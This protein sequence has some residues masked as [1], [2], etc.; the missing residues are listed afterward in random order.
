M[1]V[2]VCP[3]P[4]ATLFIYPRVCRSR[5]CKHLHMC[6]FIDEWVGRLSSFNC[7]RNPAEQ[8]LFF[9]HRR[10]GGPTPL[11]KRRHGHPPPPHRPFHHHHHDHHNQNTHRHNHHTHNRHHPQDHYHSHRHHQ[12][13]RRRQGHGCQ[14]HYHHRPIIIILV[15]SS[16]VIGADLVAYGVWPAQPPCVNTPWPAPPDFQDGLHRGFGPPNPLCKHSKAGSAR[17]P[18]WFT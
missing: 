11:S 17:F 18:R 7:S 13:S 16:T 9:L 2:C 5:V 1:R 14:H 12:H 6:G 10:V 15:I 4:T 3:S 8:A